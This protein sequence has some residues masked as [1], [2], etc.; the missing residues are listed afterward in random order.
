MADLHALL[1]AADVPGPY[2]LAGH[3]LGGAYV[4][5]YAATYPDAVVGMVLVDATNEY[6]RA[7]LTPENWAF[8]AATQGVRHLGST[9]RRLSGPTSMPCTTPWSERWPP[10]HCTSCR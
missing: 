4:R 7:E 5:L 3:S 10:S 2:V 8:L 6:Y 1:A 9:T